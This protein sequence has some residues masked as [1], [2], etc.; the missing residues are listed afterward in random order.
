MEKKGLKERKNEVTFTEFDQVYLLVH[1]CEVKLK[2]W[3]R[4]EIEKMQKAYKKS[5]DPQI[6]TGG[7]SPDSLLCMESNGMNLDSNEQKPITDQESEI[8]SS[9]EGNTVNCEL[10]IEQDRDTSEISHPGVLW[11]VFRRQDVPQLIEYLKMH[12]KEFGKPDD[13]VNE[14]VSLNL[15]LTFLHF[16]LGLLG[17]FIF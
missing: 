6:R 12:W 17:S 10:L 3:Q 1:T 11:D 8:Y 5:E 14:F 13:I 7:S 9:A 16:C 2:G 4:T 15:Y